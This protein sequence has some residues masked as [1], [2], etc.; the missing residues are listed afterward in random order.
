MGR[1]P[2]PDRKLL[3]STAPVERAHERVTA[4]KLGHGLQGT[5]Q[6]RMEAVARRIGTRII[7]VQH[8][9]PITP[10]SQWVKYALPKKPASLAKPL[11]LR[12]ASAGWKTCKFS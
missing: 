2:A 9:A 6:F 5:H 7:P 11:P 4:G 1:E 10:V 12:E 8:S 3:Q